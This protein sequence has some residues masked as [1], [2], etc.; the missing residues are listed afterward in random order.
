[1]VGILISVTIAV[2][3]ANALLTLLMWMD[4]RDAKRR[5]PAPLFDDKQDDGAKT[6]MDWASMWYSQEPRYGTTVTTTTKS[7]KPRTR[8]KK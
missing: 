4:L 8:G 2:G 3:L 6:S 7:K 1:M 5:I